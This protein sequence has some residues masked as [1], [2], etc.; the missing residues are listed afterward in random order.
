MPEF[1]LKVKDIARKKNRE[2][3]KVFIMKFLMISCGWKDICDEDLITHYS[4]N[5]FKKD[6]VLLSALINWRRIRLFFSI[7]TGILNF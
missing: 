3:R 6:V 4:D 1:L 2:K 7:F 5:G